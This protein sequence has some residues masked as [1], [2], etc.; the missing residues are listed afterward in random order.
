MLHVR[1]DRVESEMVNN[2]FQFEY[3]R[4]VRGYLCAKVR[5]VLL[6]VS[7]RVGAGAEE[8]PC[9]CFS[10]GP[11]LHEEKIIY[12]HAFLVYAGAVRWSG[13]WRSSSYVGV[14]PTCCNVEEYCFSGIK[15][16]CYHGHIG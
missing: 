16:W 9:F 5:H 4:F 10:K 7:T 13:T 1:V 2:L 12:Q 8:L 11:L 3:A 14:V 6:N 15:N